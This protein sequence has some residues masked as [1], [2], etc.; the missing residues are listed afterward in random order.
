MADDHWFKPKAYGYG[1]SP[2]NWKG[3]LAMAA[4]VVI[5]VLWTRLTLLE[6]APTAWGTVLFLGGLALLIVGFALLAK[7]K[8]EGAWHWR[9][10]K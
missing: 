5:A 7:H 4:F 2:A 9:W 8:T 6:S 10:G 1:A 3:W